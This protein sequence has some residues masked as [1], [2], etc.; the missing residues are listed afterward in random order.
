MLL[1]IGSAY[2]HDEEEVVPDGEESNTNLKR[3]SF[4]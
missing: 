4:R 3:R 1:P 2:A